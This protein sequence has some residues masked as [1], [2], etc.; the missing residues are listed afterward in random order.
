M[1]VFDYNK[2]K[3]LIKYSTSSTKQKLKYYANVIFQE[4]IKQMRNVE[5]TVSADVYHQTNNWFDVLSQVLA[6]STTKEQIL[7]LLK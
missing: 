4:F 7:N 2:K 5:V 6:M 1:C 3:D